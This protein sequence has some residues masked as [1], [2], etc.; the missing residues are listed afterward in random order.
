MITFET[1]RRADRNRWEAFIAAQPS[2]GR[3]MRSTA[4]GGPLIVTVRTGD[5]RKA[6]EMKQGGFTPTID[7]DAWLALPLVAGQPEPANEFICIQ[8]LAGEYRTYDIITVTPL[9]GYGCF[10]LGLRSRA[11]KPTAG[12][13]PPA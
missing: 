7:T 6:R 1:K 8:D 11:T 2:A 3:F 10:Q 9:L 4:N 5:A 13:P 12:Q